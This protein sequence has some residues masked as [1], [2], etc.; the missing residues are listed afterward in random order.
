[1][2]PAIWVERFDKQEILEAVECEEQWF[3]VQQYFLKGYEQEPSSYELSIYLAAQTQQF[4]A[5]SVFYHIDYSKVQVFYRRL[6]RLQKFKKLGVNFLPK[7][8]SECHFSFWNQ[9]IEPVTPREVRQTQGFYTSIRRPQEKRRHPSRVQ[10]QEP[11]SITRCSTLQN[12]NYHGS[13]TDDQIQRLP[14]VHKSFRCIPPHRPILEHLRSQGIRISAYL[15]DWILIAHSNKPN[16]KFDSSLLVTGSGLDH[17][18][19]EVSTSSNSTIRTSRLFIEY[20]GYESSPTTTK[21]SRHHQPVDQASTSG[22]ICNIPSS[23]LHQTP[24]VLQEPSSQT[25]QGSGS[26]DSFGSGEHRGAS[27]VLRESTE[28]KRKLYT[29]IDS[30]SDHI[31]GRLKY[32]M[33]MQLETLRSTRVLDTS[34]S[35]TIDRLLARTQSGSSSI[36]DFSTFRELEDSDSDRQ[37]N[38]LILHQQAGWHSIPAT[39]RISN[40]SLELV[41]RPQNNNSG[42]THQVFSKSTNSG[43]LLC[44]P[45]CRS[46]NEIITKVRILAAGSRCYPYGCLLLPMDDYNKS[47]L[48]SDLSSTP[49]DNPRATFSDNSGSFILAECSLQSFNNSQSPGHTGVVNFLTDMK[50]VHDSQ[51]STLKTMRSAVVRLHN[52]PEDIHGNIMIN[53]YLDT[54]ATQDSPVSIHRPIVDLGPA[55][56]LARSILSSPSTSS[57]L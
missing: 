20:P 45:L 12:G 1:M 22:Y 32:R 7:L 27:M 10:P 28:M 30:Q 26:T 19:E 53:S 46:H 4:P 54:I 17:K 14:C 15:D 9:A 33:R 2:F 40:R 37:H 31:C 24:A 38:Q 50:Q 11:E 36:E 52:D 41:P 5:P 42:T 51:V 21:T 34:R 23:T 13:N 18:R 49:K 25:R 39:S 47:S 3:L 55:I 57:Q 16:S 6:C 48:E 8:F 29:S 35:L 43:D 56:N 44:R